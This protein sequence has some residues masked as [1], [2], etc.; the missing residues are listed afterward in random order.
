M[1]ACFVPV[2]CCSLSLF[3][4]QQFSLHAGGRL[5][6]PKPFKVIRLGRNTSPV[7]ALGFSVTGSYLI[8]GTEHGD[9]YGWETFDWKQVPALRK[10]I[11]GSVVVA[12][13]PRSGNLALTGGQE[14]VRIVGLPSGWEVVVLKE[15]LKDVKDMAFSLDGEFLAVASKRGKIHIW[16]IETKD[17]V[18]V[19]K[20]IGKELVSISFDPGGRYFVAAS[21]G[22]VQVWDVGTWNLVNVQ[23]VDQVGIGQLQ[24]L[25]FSPDG[26]YIVVG[27]NKGIELWSADR[28]APLFTLDSHMTEIHVVVFS[29][30]GRYLAV[31]GRY[32]GRSQVRLWRVSDWEEIMVVDTPFMDAHALSIS[33]FSRFLAVSNRLDNSIWI[34]DLGNL[35]SSGSVAR[36]VDTD[37]WDTL[38]FGVGSVPVDTNMHV[39]KPARYPGGFQALSRYIQT[40][41]NLQALKKCREGDVRRDGDMHLGRMAV[42]RFYIEADG[43]V[44]QVEIIRSSGCWEVD[45]ELLRVIRSMPRWE[46]ARSLEG[47]AVRTYYVLPVVVGD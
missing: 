35:V 6:N 18:A 3:G 40:N 7:C 12:F 21:E 27:S 14:H 30:D 13:D 43:S 19:L 44:S 31:S 11:K 2:L 33:A 34:W 39:E 4:V 25:A 36:K 41:F 29:P 47:E 15:S 5:R 24:A 9:L 23:R 16:Q 22:R 32:Q 20:V 1:R 26:R 45:R 38:L 46:P 10:T 17:R 42:V 28:W 37:M 8:V